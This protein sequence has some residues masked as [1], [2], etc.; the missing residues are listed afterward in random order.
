METLKKQVHGRISTA[1]RLAGM[2][3]T[4]LSLGLA[5]GC[6]KESAAKSEPTR[7]SAT[8]GADSA[9]SVLATVGDEKITLADVKARSGDQLDKL[10]TQYQL[11]K[12]QIIGG[13]LDS[14]IRDKTVVA[15]AN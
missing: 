3:T 11:A 12:S 6:T 7:S 8:V 15:E 10:E 2:T 5:V 4:V 14:L 9:A 13:S 1:R